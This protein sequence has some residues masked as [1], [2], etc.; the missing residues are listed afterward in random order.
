[1]RLP[2]FHADAPGLAIHD[3]LSALLG[4]AEDG[5]FHYG[6]AD[7][8]RL[9]GHSCPTVAGAYLMTVRSLGHL[10]GDALPVRGEIEVHPRDE[11]DAGVAG[12]M[13]SVATLL[14]GAAQETGFKGLGGR[15]DRRRL[16]IFG[17]AIEG[18]MAFRRRDNGAGV[19]AFL[20]AGVVPADP[21]ADDLLR[22]QLAGQAREDEGARFRELWQG[23]I[24]RLLVDHADNPLPIRLEDWPS[25]V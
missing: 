20:N 15:F 23:R 3:P 10:Y 17:A 9:A 21:E 13:A 25:D 22:R 5:V 12:V 1:M 2:S 19:Q 11:A 18:D 7:A 14:T 8:V 24:R 4:A 6:Y 16:L